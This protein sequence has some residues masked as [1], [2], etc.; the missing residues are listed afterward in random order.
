M[1]SAIVQTST[2]VTLLGAGDATIAQI[3]MALELAPI[4]VGVDGGANTAILHDLVPEAVI[5]DFDSLRDDVA[6]RIPADRQHRVAEQDTTDF[7]KALRSVLAPLSIAVGFTGA[8]LDHTLAALN[9]LVKH[10]SRR[11]ILTSQQDAVVLLPPRLELSLPTGTR[12][13]L[14]PM[15]SVKVTS[16]G[17][18]WPT[19]GIDFSPDG[20]VGTSNEAMGGRIGLLTSAPLMLLALPILEIVC[21]LDA[22]VLSPSWH[23]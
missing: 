8:R 10:R 20:T 23:E 4:L 21:L 15:G 1:V 2:F 18:K 19:D 3:R 13:S 16:E 22:L 14:F 9:V 7:D 12:V 17:L 5:G 6:R 11:C